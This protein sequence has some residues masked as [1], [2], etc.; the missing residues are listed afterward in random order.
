MGPTGDR[1]DR[2]P[3]G[4]D[5][6]QG[7]EGKQGPGGVAGP[8]GPAGSQGPAGPATQATIPRHLSVDRIDFGARWTVADEGPALVFR[9]KLSGGDKRIAMWQGNYRDI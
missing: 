1:G 4:S 5:G 3:T 7:P 6:K 9:D 2:G 8:V